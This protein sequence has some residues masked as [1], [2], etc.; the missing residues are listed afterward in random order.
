MAESYA[1][2]YQRDGYVVVGD[3]LTPA[4][5]A[6][7][8]H[9][10]DAWVEES[11]DHD[12]PYGVTADERARFDIEPGHTADR[13]ALRRVASPVEVSDAYLDAMRTAPVVDVVADVV[14]P[15]V[16]FNN[17]KINSK[18]PGAMTE[19]KFHQDFMFQPH[20][21]DGLVAVLIF[22]DDVT[23]DNGPLEVVPGT[24]H[25]E[26]FSH[27]HG[28]VYTG[29]VA[30][31]V[32]EAH[33]TDA[34]SITGPAGTACLMHTRLLHGSKPNSSDQPRTL[35]IAEY[36]AEDSKPLQVNHLPSTYED[37]V[38][39]GERTNTVRC[40][41]Y[42]MVFPEVPTEASFFDQQAKAVAP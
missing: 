20:T 17:S 29:T 33:V 23:D 10:F 21:N 2:R 36:R 12:T 16:C 28:G 1:E 40:T 13:P 4:Q 22:L 15:N 39:R 30:S 41:P 32:V 9:D 38:V 24:H 14:G 18:Q 27:W 31:E 37:E 19:V 7:L 11:R 26:L 6:A 3:A 34:V 8:R 25:G 42:E 5:L 35:F